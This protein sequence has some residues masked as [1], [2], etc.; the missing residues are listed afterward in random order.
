[1]LGMFI[2]QSLSGSDTIVFYSLDI[3]RRADVQLNNYVLSIFVQSGFLFG[4]M[5]AAFLMSRVGRKAQ[6]IMSG[7]FMAI[8]LSALGL[9][10][11]LNLEVRTKSY[12][13][14]VFCLC[15]DIV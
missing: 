13:I 5:I 12:S 14:F 2:L 1:M 4:F 3:F 8:F 9:I 11:K 7:L 6:F 15:V 10:L